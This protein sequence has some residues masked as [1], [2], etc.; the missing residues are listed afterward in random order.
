MPTN[1]TVRMRASGLIHGGGGDD[2]GWDQEIQ[3]SH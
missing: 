1:L 3:M 2:E